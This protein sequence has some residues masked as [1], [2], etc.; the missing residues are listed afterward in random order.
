MN[1][2]NNQSFDDVYFVVAPEESRLGQLAV[3]PQINGKEVTW[4]KATSRPGKV[5]KP[6]LSVK[7]SDN[8]ATPESITIVL[9]DGTE[10]VLKKLYEELY[11][12]KVRP[13]VLDMP[14]LNELKSNLLNPK[15][16][17]D[18]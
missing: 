5:E 15:K 14:E 7:V 13:W 18:Y 11:N 8:T 1:P 17:H 2:V 12:E 16:I 3:R 10:V 9:R 6:I 4:E